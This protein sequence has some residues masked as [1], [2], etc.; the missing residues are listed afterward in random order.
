[1]LTRHMPPL[2]DL[3]LGVVCERRSGDKDGLGR[4]LAN[5]PLADASA[6]H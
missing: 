5:L 6:E 3:I 4:I 2:W 1:M